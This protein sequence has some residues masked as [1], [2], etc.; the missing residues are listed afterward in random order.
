MQKAAA[1][2]RKIIEIQNMASQSRPQAPSGAFNL[3][4]YINNN[5]GDPVTVKVGGL[6]K[7]GG[8]FIV[9]L[10]VPVLEILGGPVTM[11]HCEYLWKVGH[12]VFTMGG[13]GCYI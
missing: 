5:M 10:G 7:V 3:S 9:K 13:H 2:Q 8:P 6:V 12:F 4:I 1:I 11:D